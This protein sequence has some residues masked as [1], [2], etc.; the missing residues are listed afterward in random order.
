M[1]GVKHCGCRERSLW[2]Q[3]MFSHCYEPGDMMMKA[4]RR[5]TR[6]NNSTERITVSLVEFC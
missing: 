2:T 5:A 6:S 3:M 1:V 4:G